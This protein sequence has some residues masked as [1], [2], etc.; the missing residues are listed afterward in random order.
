MSKFEEFE[1][2][3]SEC[4]AAYEAVRFSDVACKVTDI[5]FSLYG[6]MIYF[7]VKN[8]A[9]LM[10][11]IDTLAQAGFDTSGRTYHHYS[12]NEGTVYFSYGKNSQASAAIQA[13]PNDLIQFGFEVQK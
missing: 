9:Q 13:N 3:E 1:K 11:V 2:I 7:R 6:M 10:D 4:E 12:E 5:H 8:Q